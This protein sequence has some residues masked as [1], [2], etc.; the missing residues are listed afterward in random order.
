MIVPIFKCGNIDNARNYR[1]ITL[2]NIIEKVYSQIL[3]NRLTEWADNR[4]SISAIQCGF[5]KGKSTVDCIFILNTIISKTLSETKN[6][7]VL[8]LT[9]KIVLIR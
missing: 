2:I 5:Q 9:S 6:Y 4:N 8:S 7:I 1:G 3:L